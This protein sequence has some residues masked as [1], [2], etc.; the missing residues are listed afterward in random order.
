[1]QHSAREVVGRNQVDR[2]AQPID[3][4]ALEGHAEL[5]GAADAARAVRHLDRSC[6]EKLAVYERALNVASALAPDVAE[7]YQVARVEHAELE[8]IDLARKHAHG[9]LGL[10]RV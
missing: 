8:R 10:R 1:M 6:D 4:A 7:E 2:A 3:G 5:G 9:D